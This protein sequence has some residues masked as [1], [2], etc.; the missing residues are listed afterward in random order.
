[1]E[2]DEGRETGL[3]VACDGEAASRVTDIYMEILSKKIDR[4]NSAGEAASDGR[5]GRQA[6]RRGS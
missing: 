5:A 4:G 1:M 6:A 3:K 2:E